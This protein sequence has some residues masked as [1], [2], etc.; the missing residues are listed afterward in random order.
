MSA[1]PLF[2]VWCGRDEPANRIISLLWSSSLQWT[3]DIHLFAACA[4]LKYL[5]HF[6]VIW[7]TNCIE[8]LKDPH[9]KTVTAAWISL[10]FF[11]GQ[12]LLQC[13]WKVHQVA[14]QQLLCSVV[15]SSL[16]CLTMIGTWNM[17]PAAWLKAH[18]H[19]AAFSHI[20]SGVK[21][22]WGSPR[23]SGR[24]RGRTEVTVKVLNMA[25]G[26][27]VFDKQLLL[28]PLPLGFSLH[29]NHLQGFYRACS[30]EEKVSS[31]SWKAEG[32]KDGPDWILAASLAG[33]RCIILF[34]N[35]SWVNF[36]WYGAI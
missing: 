15:N 5:A 3:V 1:G 4:E 30:R 18:L 12:K 36:G 8:D 13:L 16:V 7:I 6:R 14:P 34:R 27:E 29:H 2:A 31:M 17:K 9:C 22:T 32:A 23:A 20:D 35:I 28:L 11:S 24:A 19:L 25:V 26:C 33:W 10:E 21:R